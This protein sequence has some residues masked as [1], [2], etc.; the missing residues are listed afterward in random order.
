MFVSIVILSVCSVS[1]RTTAPLVLEDQAM[2][3]SMEYVLPY[4]VH[5]LLFA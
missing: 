3:P 1:D 5:A 2:L 4:A